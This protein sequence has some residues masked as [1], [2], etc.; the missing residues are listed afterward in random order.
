MKRNLSKKAVVIRF[1]ILGWLLYTKNEMKFERNPRYI[2]RLYSLSFLAFFSLI[3]M[4]VLLVSVKTWVFLEL[5]LVL[6]SCF[7]G[8]WASKY[9]MQYF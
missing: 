9:F 8:F 6:L 3:V 2:F 5:F 1:G 7:Y 4:L